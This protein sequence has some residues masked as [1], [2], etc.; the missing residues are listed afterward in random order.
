MDAPCL[1]T[2]PFG[3]KVNNSSAGE[4]QD[5]AVEIPVRLVKVQV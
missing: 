3:K 1:S 2:E 4:G 5:N